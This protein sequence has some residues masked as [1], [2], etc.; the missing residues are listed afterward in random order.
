[1]IGKV[2]F[3]SAP[4]R[5]KIGYTRQ[6]EQRLRGLQYS[7]MEQLTMLAVIDGTRKTE[8]ML[9]ALLARHRLR[10][11]WFDDHEEVRATIAKAVAGNFAPQPEAPVP[12]RSPLSAP[13]FVN[14][15]VLGDCKRLADE[16]IAAMARGEDKND[17]RA[18]TSA[19]IAVSGILLGKRLD[20]ISHDHGFDPPQ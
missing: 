13:V 3:V 14:P 2:Y 4:G 11:E 19:L 10:G 9:H 12:A 6:P 5:I 16:V 17:V 7:D 1:M 20:A 8:Q 18:R 15:T